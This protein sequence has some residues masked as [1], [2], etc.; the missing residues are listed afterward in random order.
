MAAG[1]GVRVGRF[2]AGRARLTNFVRADRMGGVAVQASASIPVVAT[3]RWDD[4]LVERV[5]TWAVAWAPAAVLVRGWGDRY[6]GEHYVWLPPGDI[7]RLPEG[8]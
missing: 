5:R 2:V 7:E 8:S 1:R 3:L 4:G 6:G